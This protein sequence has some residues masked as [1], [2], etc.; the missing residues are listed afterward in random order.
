[1]K[2]GND[3]CMGLYGAVPVNYIVLIW[4]AVLS[5]EFFHFEQDFA[6]GS[7]VLHNFS[8][9][10]FDIQKTLISTRKYRLG[11]ILA[12]IKFICATIFS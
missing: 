12:I 8:S 1:M 5:L 11:I 3:S 7:F 10:L 2:G 4:R 6:C 9:H